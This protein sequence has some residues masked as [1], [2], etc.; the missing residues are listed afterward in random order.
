MKISLITYLCAFNVILGM[1][2]L[3]T[4]CGG[5]NN[6]DARE[7]L[8][9]ASFGFQLLNVKTD[10]DLFSTPAYSIDSVRLLSSGFSLTKRISGIKDNILRIDK[11]YNPAQNQ[12]GKRVDKTFYLYFNRSD[13][14]TIRLSFLPV[15]GKCDPYFTDY[16][17]FYNQRLVATDQNT[18]S[19]FTKINKL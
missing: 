17:V 5:C 1:S 14:D 3:L 2:S 15:D 13:T 7:N 19:F 8:N 12:I 11:I 4:G 6:R 16:Q 9:E 18:I 10:Q